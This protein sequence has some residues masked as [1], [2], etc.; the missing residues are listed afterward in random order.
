MTKYIFIISILLKTA[1]LFS[2]ND[3]LAGKKIASFPG[4]KKEMDKFIYENLHIPFR[5]TGMADVTCYVSFTVAKDGE[6]KNIKICKPTKG[7]ES[8]DIRKTEFEKE[9]L[10]IIEKMPNWIP[11]MGWRKNK[12]NIIKLSIVF[13]VGSIL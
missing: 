2:Q 13:N 9:A 12:E 10:E 3:I 7:V 4:G 8:D 5:G 11:K 6:L 1:F